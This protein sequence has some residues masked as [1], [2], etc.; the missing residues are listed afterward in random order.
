LALVAS[1]FTLHALSIELRI[2]ATVRG[3]GQDRKGNMTF[4]PRAP[5]FS[6]VDPDSNRDATRPERELSAFKFQEN[7]A[8]A[9]NQMYLQFPK[10]FE[11]EQEIKQQMTGESCHK[12][13]LRRWNRS[14]PNIAITS[15]SDSLSPGLRK[16]FN[17]VGEI[18]LHAL[19]EETYDEVA[20]DVSTVDE[21]DASVE[22]GQ[23]NSAS[24]QSPDKKKTKRFRWAFFYAMV[25]DGGAKLT[26]IVSP[27]IKRAS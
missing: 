26:H 9:S 21:G 22:G 7:T 5:P 24:E 15:K 2:F 19:S 12:R 27:T 14:D 20:E 10:S 3:R 1:S 13:R 16:P 11:E 4:L 25:N 23:T 6:A 17:S 8:F 18:D